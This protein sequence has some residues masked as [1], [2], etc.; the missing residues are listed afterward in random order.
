MVTIPASVPADGFR[1]A[2]D[3]HRRQRNA[4]RL[5][6]ARR[7]SI[8]VGDG[9]RVVESAETA[10]VESLVARVKKK[11]KH[12]RTWDEPEAQASQVQNVTTSKRPDRIKTRRRLM[13][14]SSSTARA[15]RWPIALQEDPY[16]DFGK[17]IKQHSSSPAVALHNVLDSE[18]RTS[19]KSPI[20][21]LSSAEQ[22]NGGR[23]GPETV[24]SAV[25]PPRDNG[26]GVTAT[27]RTR[28]QPGR[29]G[30]IT[31]AAGGSRRTENLTE[32]VYP[33]ARFSRRNNHARPQ[34]DV[35]RCLSPVADSDSRTTP[36]I[37]STVVT[38]V[39]STSAKG[40]QKRN[41]TRP[42]EPPTGLES[43]TVVTAAATAVYHRPLL[44]TSSA[45]NNPAE[46]T[47]P[48]AMV[49][50][51]KHLRSRYRNISLPE[52]LEITKVNRRRLNGTTETVT[53]GVPALI[54]T[55]PSVLPPVVVDSTEET[56]VDVVPSTTMT[57][58]TNA[59]DSD[60]SASSV[61]PPSDIQDFIYLNNGTSESPAAVVTATGH[62]NGARQRRPPVSTLQRNNVTATKPSSAEHD[63]QGV[64]NSEGLTA[65]TYLFSLLAI[66]PLVL[67]IV[68]AFCKLAVRRKRKKVFDS[69]EYSSEYNRS[70]LD[71]NT[72]SSSPI[73]TKLPRVPQ[74]MV[75][76]VS[77]AA[78]AVADKV[79]SSPL[80]P[81]SQSL[82]QPLPP[83]PPL[84]QTA[85]SLSSNGRWEFCRD[86]LRLQ[87]ILGQGNF[88]QVWKAEADDISGHE[89]LTRLVA[90]KMV[91]EDA[92]SRER[93]DLIRE[94]GIMQHLGSHPNVVTLLACCT[95]KGTPSIRLP[96][97]FRST[98][99]GVNY[100]AASMLFILVPNQINRKNHPAKTAMV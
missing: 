64:V 55:L 65:S 76:D 58:T 87:T 2:T 79:S 34:R 5:T 82:P 56:V 9:A 6:G 68:F 42:L 66:V 33:A 31:A 35:V 30:H 83:P 54:S 74:H 70:P 48:A 49:T 26:S 19:I 29:N 80:Q 61:P 78:A 72:V 91:K 37:L 73:T 67:V 50:H 24:E 47:V 92:A 93:E 32:C 88:G 75:W 12:K 71:F 57:M 59:D 8:P 7:T 38:S 16:Y 100:C 94:L 36:R 77:T 53:G 89:G 22:D 90:V 81:T 60:T 23:D 41:D 46:P 95:E 96:R 45:V 17:K 13:V 63:V 51:P 98:L 4:T 18:S 20:V 97:V 3:H 39:S 25:E 40:N 52:Y 85:V 27:T 10:D 62:A 1:P 86:K 99:S 43:T 15:L 11:I 44:R 28:T 14:P 21:V 84:Q 69:S